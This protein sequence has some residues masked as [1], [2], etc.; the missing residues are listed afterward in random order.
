MVSAGVATT[1]RAFL[2]VWHLSGQ[3]KSAQPSAKEQTDR[4]TDAPR[5]KLWHT[6]IRV[7]LSGVGLGETKKK[8]LVSFLIYVSSDAKPLSFITSTGLNDQSVEI[9]ETVSNSRKLVSP[10]CGN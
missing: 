9:L 10:S 3:L 2:T 4:V 1:A 6:Q 5:S 7:I 8:C